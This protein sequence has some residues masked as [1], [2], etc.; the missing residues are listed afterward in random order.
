MKIRR[1]WFKM[2]KIGINYWYL[3]I[4]WCVDLS[5]ILKVNTVEEYCGSSCR[6]WNTP[7]RQL[8][9][10]L[11]LIKTL[12]DHSDKDYTYM[13]MTPTHVP[14]TQ[15]HAQGHPIGP[16]NPRRACSRS[17]TLYNGKR[18]LINVNIDK[19]KKEHV[20]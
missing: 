16:Q 8:V 3:R 18:K 7:P 9:A 13:Y 19:S 20:I 15:H 1:S 14:S 10:Y 6:A 2:W 4:D 17:L 11:K 12:F 5:L